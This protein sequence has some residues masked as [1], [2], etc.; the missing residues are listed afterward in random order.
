MEN[1]AQLTP[2]TPTAAPPSSIL[3]DDNGTGHFIPTPRPT[4]KQRHEESL[5]MRKALMVTVPDDF[6]EF[7]WK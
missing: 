3:Y 4:H 5:S 6:L 1:T 7:D 2:T